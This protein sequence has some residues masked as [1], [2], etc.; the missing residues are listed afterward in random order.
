[1]PRKTPFPEQTRAARYAALGVALLVLGLRWWLVHLYGVE[2]PFWDQWDAEV[3]ALLRPWQQGRLGLAALFTPHNEH[4]IV[5]TRLFSLALF[6]A[7]GGFSPRLE[8]LIQAC[9]PAIGAGALTLLL[10]RD[11]PRARWSPLLL[12]AVL[13]GAHPL[14]HENLLSGFQSAV[15]FAALFSLLALV[16]ACSRGPTPLTWPRVALC[17]ALLS[18]AFASLASGTLAALVVCLVWAT[19]AA[20][21]RSDR[22]AWLR[23]LTVAVGFSALLLVATPHVPAHD[24]LRAASIGDALRAFML[25]LGW[26]NTPFS[27]S[28]VV[29][30]W[31]P[32]TAA[33]AHELAHRS[34]DEEA[35]LPTALIVF[36]SSLMVATA[37]RRGVGGMG[38]ALRS[39]ESYLVAW[40]CAALFALRL[41][42]R[43]PR[44]ARLAGAWLL[45]L[46][47]GLG[48]AA[49]GAFDDL[50]ESRRTRR[51]M[52]D[53]IVTALELEALGADSGRRYLAS[54][55]PGVDLPYPDAARLWQILRSPGVDAA[56]PPGL[57]PSPGAGSRAAPAEAGLLEQRWLAALLILI[58]AA[59]LGVGQGPLVRAGAEGGDGAED[60]EG[61]EDSG[62]AE[63]SEQVE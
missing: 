46:V 2:V 27:Y 47:L 38:P 14:T 54:G 45:A 53:R 35:W 24:G 51:A 34:F 50:V 41:A 4:Y 1:M 60:G 52:R 59:L 33:I 13:A 21:S 31:A 55:Q 5:S 29:L 30:L 15:F 23:R 12:I 37:W 18:A 42:R 40:P 11:L 20:A 58:G 9:L 16:V 57:R 62:G 17:L 61:T 36:V 43:G 63:G 48:L 56:L 10:L 28:S 8:M 44:A 22:P 3:D 6:S 25:S 19:R 26:P 39:A 7:H 32:L 49:Y